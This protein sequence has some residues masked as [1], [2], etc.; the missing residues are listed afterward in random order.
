MREAAFHTIFVGIETPE[1]DALKQ[2]AKDHN[3]S[4]PMLDAIRTLN[5][6]GLEVT[7]GIILGLDTDSAGSEEKLIDFMEASQVP[8]LTINLLQ[9]LPKTPLWDRLER[10]GRLVSDPMLESNVQFLRPHDDVVASW[11]RA[12][13]YAYDPE[14]LFAR[15]RHQIDNTYANRLATPAKAKLT[16]SNLKRGLVLAYNIALRVG[17]L[18]DYRGPFWRASWHAIRSGQIEAVFGMGFVA[19]HLIRFTREAL[20]GEHNASFYAAKARA[21]EE[22]RSVFPFGRLLPSLRS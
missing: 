15:L 11:R 17:I 19:H 16:A 21:R 1:L 6:Y 20:R 7:S 18:S 2:M 3:A 8:I 4:L 12:I 13:A 9:A 10:E 22:R 14:R 5:Q